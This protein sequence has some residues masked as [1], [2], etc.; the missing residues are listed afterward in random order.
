MRNNSAPGCFVPG[1]VQSVAVAAQQGGSGFDRLDG[2]SSVALG[3]GVHRPQERIEW[4][5]W[6]M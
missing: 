2:S 3:R 6:S 1:T 5:F 4:D